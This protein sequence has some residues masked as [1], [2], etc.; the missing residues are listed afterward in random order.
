MIKTGKK[1]T[2]WVWRLVIAVEIIVALW[3]VYGDWLTHIRRN[4]VKNGFL[5]LYPT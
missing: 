1:G 4:A 2:N 5:Q 3:L